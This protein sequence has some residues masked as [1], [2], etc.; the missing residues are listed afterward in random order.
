MLSSSS[1]ARRGP[2][3]VLIVDD[4]AVVRQLLTRDLNAVPGIEVVGGAPDPYVA[5]D[6][7]VKLKPDVMTLDVEMPRMDGITFLKLLMRHRPT[8]AIVVSSLTPVGSRTAIEAMEAGA[9]ISALRVGRH[10]MRPP[11]GPSCPHFSQRDR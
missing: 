4:S 10:S 3:R 5:R 1:T 8:P 9:A 2:I 7:V 11:A 6:M